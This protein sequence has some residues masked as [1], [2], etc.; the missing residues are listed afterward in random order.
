MYTTYVI[1]FVMVGECQIS[2]TCVCGIPGCYTYTFMS[3]MCLYRCLLYS[4]G[5]NPQDSLYTVSLGTNEL[6]CA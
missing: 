4:K 1:K 6:H 2:C 3:T 5:C